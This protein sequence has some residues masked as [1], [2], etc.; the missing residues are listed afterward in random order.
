MTA[1]LSP[2]PVQKFWTNGGTPLAYGLVYTYSAGSTTP[3]ATYTDSTAATQ[4]ANPIVLNARGEA[5]IWLTPNVAY[6][7][8][9]TDANG[10]T[11]LTTDQIV[12]SQLL[13]L[14]GGVDTGSAN[15]YIVNFTANFSSYTNGVIVVFIPSN[16]NTG[17]STININGL[18][19]IAI[20]NANGTPLAA[21]SITSGNPAQVLIYQGAALLQNPNVIFNN[22]IILLTLTGITGTQSGDAYYTQVGNS[23]TCTLPTLLGTSNAA[24]CTMIGATTADTAKIMA[25]LPTTQIPFCPLAI[26]VNSGTYIGGGF[27]TLNHGNPIFTLGFN[28]VANGWTA[29]ANKGGGGTITWLLN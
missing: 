25:I 13:T 26:C 22:G 7:F 23:V 28:G 15:A 11:V 20:T 14:F 12:A 10:N 19:V 18:G 6:K 9:V 8:V 4:N 3:T 27:V 1:V 24:T 5:N 2:A 16:S 29:S 17:A 21:G